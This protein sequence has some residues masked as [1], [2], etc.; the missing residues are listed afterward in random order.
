[1]KDI[2]EYLRIFF[3]NDFLFNFFWISL[4]YSEAKNANADAIVP[5]NNL[6]IRY[7]R[8]LVVDANMTIKLLNIDFQKLLADAKKWHPLVAED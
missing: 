6:P 1:L 4:G 3:S 8:A 7:S 2:I 5:N